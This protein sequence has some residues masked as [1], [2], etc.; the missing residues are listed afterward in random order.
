MNAMEN[1]VIL[2]GGKPFKEIRREMTFVL[3][4]GAYKTY[5]IEYSGGSFGSK[6]MAIKVEG[7]THLSTKEFA[8]KPDG[9]I[10]VDTNKSGREYCNW[11]CKDCDKECAPDNKL[12]CLQAF[13]QVSNNIRG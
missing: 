5:G 2:P 8:I 11:E 13:L 7:T 1:D 3:K 12:I 4:N 6:Y 10:E 9:S